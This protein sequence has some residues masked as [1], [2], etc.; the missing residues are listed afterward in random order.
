MRWEG[1]LIGAEWIFI[2]GA[3]GANYLNQ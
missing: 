3:A 2:E 1:H